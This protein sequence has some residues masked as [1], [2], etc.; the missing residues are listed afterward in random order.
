MG[1]REEKKARARAAMALA[2]ADLFG[3]HGYAEVAMSQ[4]AKA[5]GVSDQT[6]YNYFPTKESLVFDRAEQFEHTLRARVAHRPAG[7]EVVPAFRRWFDEFVFGPAAERAL[8]RP[9]GMVRLV[10]GSEA[11]HRALL[12]LAHRAAG[13]LAAELADRP[14]ARATVLADALVA[15]YL[16][17]VEELGTAPGPEAIPGIAERG[18]ARLDVLADLD[19]A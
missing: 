3:R 1:L 9:G 10:A 4:I 6:L 18:H 8:T 16:R 11:L 2:A 17:A 5:A 19:R 13:T 14:P 15:V 12:D 7:E